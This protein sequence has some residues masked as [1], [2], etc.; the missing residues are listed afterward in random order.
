[1]IE[2]FEQ[3]NV[4]GDWVLM[5]TNGKTY[6]RIQYRVEFRT[7]DS[8]Y[9]YCRWYVTYDVNSVIRQTKVWLKE[10]DEEGESFKS[11]QI[12]NEDTEKLVKE[13]KRVASVKR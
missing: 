10:Y 12:I 8:D 11:I 3:K 4:D 13:Y 1:M 5:D 9:V 7:A 6:P 2:K